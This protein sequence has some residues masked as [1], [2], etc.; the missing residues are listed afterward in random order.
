[1]RTTAIIHLDRFLANFQT[2]KKRVGNRQI[3]VP[4]KADAYGHGAQKIA[5]AAIKA[6]ADCLG[7]GTVNEGAE[8]RK[9]GI[10]A[11]ILL[12]T[13]PN[14]QEIP[15]LIEAELTPFVSDALFASALNDQ[16]K[17]ASKIISVHL[18]IDSGMG[19]AGCSTVDSEFLSLANYI[20]SCP[21]LKLT[22]TATHFAASDSTAQEDIAHTKLQIER[23]NKAIEAIKADGIDPGIVHSANSG[24]IFLHEDSWFDM[25]RP[26]LFLYGYDLT[27]KEPALPVME[28]VS[29]IS[30]IKKI[31][32]GDSVS[33]GMTWKAPCDTF[34]GIL[35]IGYAD[36]LPRAASGKWQFIINGKSYPGIGRICMD[37]CC[38]DLGTDPETKKLAIGDKAIVFG[39][40]EHGNGQCAAS[41]AE[42]IGTIPYEIT[43]NIGKR[44]P[45]E[46]ISKV[47]D[48]LNG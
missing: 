7:V 12:F 20:S 25:V 48:P 4:V 14:P 38:I 10:S 11:V 6:G 31:K 27:G 8:L 15:A 46:Y 2:V 34:I 22:G 28:L 21:N 1:M 33:Y 16:A 36:G 19:R 47:V 43:C 40:K 35:P 24:G 37:Q 39:G 30:L 18:K 17:I 9:T 23:F 29:N 3:C 32:K 45:R 13:Q 5:E 41:L 42:V 44:V 26:G